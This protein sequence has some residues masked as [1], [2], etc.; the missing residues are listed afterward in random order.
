[1]VE[2]RARHLTAELDWLDTVLARLDQTPDSYT[3]E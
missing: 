3:E 2:H 1:M